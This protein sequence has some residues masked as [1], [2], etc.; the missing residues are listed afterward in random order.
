MAAYTQ[1]LRHRRSFRPLPTDSAFPSTP[2]LRFQQRIC[3]SKLTY[4]SL[5]LQPADLFASLVGADRIASAYRDFYYRASR[6][7]ITLL[8]AGYRY[9][10]NWVSSIGW[11][12]TS[13]INH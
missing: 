9:D 7:S 2:A 5:A 3:I 1:F 13:E 11:T 8:P 4:R 12:S 6:E 10:G